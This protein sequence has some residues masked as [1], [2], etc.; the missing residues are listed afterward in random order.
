MQIPKSIWDSVSPSAKWEER[1]WSL[2]SIS[3][4]NEMAEPRPLWS[5]SSLSHYP[6]KCFVL[7]FT[8][9]VWWGLE[10]SARFFPPASP[11][12]SRPLHRLPASPTAALPPTRFLVPPAAPVRLFAVE[13]AHSSYCELLSG[14]HTRRVKEGI[15]LRGHAASLRGD[16]PESCFRSARQPRPLHSTAPGC[17][18]AARRVPPSLGLAL[19]HGAEVTR[20]RPT[21]RKAG[22]AR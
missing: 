22:K 10:K 17:P 21:T 8:E 18:R 2:E 12:R 9:R 1:T 16:H 14:S 6:R 11:A 15:G 5:P 13:R 7:F 3:Q 19:V 4:T 20:L